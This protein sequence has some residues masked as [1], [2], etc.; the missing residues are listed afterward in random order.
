MDFVT[1]LFIS[2][3]RKDKIYDII[4]VIINWL[5]KMIYYEPVKLI[6]NNKTFAGVIIEA[7]V[8]HHELLDLIVMIVT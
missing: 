5:I 1:R 3:N 2:I 4:S 8:W 7:V 6:I